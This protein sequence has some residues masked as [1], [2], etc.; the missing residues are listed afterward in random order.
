[1]LRGEL[2]GDGALWA[3]AHFEGSRESSPTPFRT[4][5]RQ[6]RNFGSLKIRDIRSAC[7]NVG[8]E[9]QR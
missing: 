3:P 9:A 7:L 5:L 1:M 2:A 6:E 8:S 4:T